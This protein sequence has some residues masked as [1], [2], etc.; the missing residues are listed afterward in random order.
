MRVLS[1]TVLLALAGCNTKEPALETPYL[2]TAP[3]SV[4]TPLPTP[5]SA[6]TLIKLDPGGIMGGGSGHGTIVLGFP[7]DEDTTVSLR[8]ADPVVTVAPSE[9]T[10]ARGRVSAEFDFSVRPVSSDRNAAIV[11]T[12]PAWSASA[13]IAA[14]A[15][16]PQFLNVLG[17]TGAAPGG[18][19]AVRFTDPNTRFTGYCSGNRVIASTFTP[20]TGENWQV[21]FG[22]A[23]GAFRPGTY[24]NAAGSGAGRPF[25]RVTGPFCGT[26]GTG[27]FVVH[28][29]EFTANGQV[30]RFWATFEQS[31]SG[32]P[33]TTIRGDVRFLDLPRQPGTTCLR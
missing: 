16:L 30:L 27:R 23:S 17:N 26:S 4:T 9:V 15:V 19:T 32:A 12:T 6:P 29:A 20:A 22:A 24:D 33:A 5:P 31:C 8:S 1:L 11:A 7:P 21:Q 3:T 10:I 18:G 13:T 25:I 28:E 2:A 14:W